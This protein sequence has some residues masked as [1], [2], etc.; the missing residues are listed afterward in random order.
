MARPIGDAGIAAG[1]SRLLAIRAVEERQQVYLGTDGEIVVHGQI[2]RHTQTVDQ[3]A[4]IEIHT[5]WVVDVHAPDPGRAQQGGH[6]VQPIGIDITDTESRQLRRPE[7]P[8]R[9]RAGQRQEH[10]LLSG[11]STN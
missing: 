4:Y 10:R 3:P 1:A 2:E 11:S 7:G 9:A 6:L 8:P 5:D